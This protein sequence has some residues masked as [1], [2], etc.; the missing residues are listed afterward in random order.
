MPKYKKLEGN[1]TE[2]ETDDV[3]PVYLTQAIT[4]SEDDIDGNGPPV[5]SEQNVKQAKKWV[6]EH[7]V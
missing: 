1:L 5:I 4:E 6:D 2:I 7:K 3:V